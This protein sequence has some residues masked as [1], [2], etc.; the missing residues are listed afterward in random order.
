LSCP[1]I[2]QMYITPMTLAARVFTLYYYLMSSKCFFTL[3]IVMIDFNVGGNMV[4]S[5]FT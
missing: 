3:Q 4:I 1:S 2:L 5:H